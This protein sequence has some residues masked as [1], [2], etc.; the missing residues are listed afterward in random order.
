MGTFILKPITYSKFLKRI[1]LC[2]FLSVLIL[3][4]YGK[5]HLFAQEVILSSLHRTLPQAQIYNSSHL[6]HDATHF[7]LGLGLLQ[8]DVGSM[9]MSLQKFTSFTEGKTLDIQPFL[10]E[11]FQNGSVNTFLET[12]WSLWGLGHRINADHYISAGMN[13]RSFSSFHIPEAAAAFFIHGNEISQD[14]S[15][16]KDLTYD[17]SSTNFRI[18]VFSELYFGYTFRLR[19]DM[20]LSGKVKI[21][22]GFYGFEMDD[23]PLQITTE[24]DSYKSVLNMARE[25]RAVAFNKDLV[26]TENILKNI[27][28]GFDFGVYWQVSPHIS[29][30][31][32]LNDILGNVFWSSPIRNYLIQSKNHIFEGSKVDGDN[33][34]DRYFGIALENIKKSFTPVEVVNP[35]VNSSMQIPIS[36][37]FG[38][39]YTVN[40]RN[41]FSM[42]TSGRIITAIAPPEFSHAFIYN[43]NYKNI[44][45]AS[46]SIK[47]DLR[48]QLTFGLGAT[49]N[50]KALQLYFATDDLISNFRTIHAQNL[51][52]S[53]G[54]NFTFGKVRPAV[55]DVSRRQYRL[56]EFLLQGTPP[57]K[58][59]DPN[60]LKNIMNQIE[61]D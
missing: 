29:L 19:Q 52:F 2:T 56:S 21:Y 7:S 4:L 40:Y 45:N 61:I 8:L 16:A 33:I 55:H 31:M 44:I 54:I 11:A 17:F 9:P 51:N 42:L 53:F 37:Q 59:V 27:G 60:D 58:P 35:T 43:Y 30:N 38:V 48:D 46:T 22:N 57:P 26:T 20:R 49:C 18:Q 36:V 28:F 32:A 50:I 14:E 15:S 1:R 5:N 41:T 6:V 10:Q 13:F 3:L 47:Y 39:N 34:G 23:F 25:F 12:R 24:Y